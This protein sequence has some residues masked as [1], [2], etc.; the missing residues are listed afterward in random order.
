MSTIEKTSRTGRHPVN[1]GHLV[2]GLAFLG[3]LAIWTVVQSDAVEWEQVR[4]LLP[5]P[6]ILAGGAGLAASVLS[7]RRHVQQQQ[8][9]VPPAD[10][11][12][13]RADAEEDDDPFS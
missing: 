12:A 9:W 1:V 7:G 4:W 5:V 2:M 13:L 3:L 11:P 6:W 10:E 8:G